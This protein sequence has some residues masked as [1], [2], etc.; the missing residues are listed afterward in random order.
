MSRFRDSIY[1]LLRKNTTNN[2]IKMR[3]FK[4]FCFKRHPNGKVN[5]SLAEVKA[6]GGSRCSLLGSG[7]R[8]GPAGWAERSPEERWRGGEK[9]HRYT[10][11]QETPSANCWPQR[12]ILIVGWASERQGPKYGL[13]EAPG[14]HESEPAGQKED[15]FVL[16]TVKLSYWSP[17]LRITTFLKLK[18]AKL[19]ACLWLTPYQIK[20]SLQLNIK[21]S[22]KC[23]NICNILMSAGAPSEGNPVGKTTVSWWMIYCRSFMRHWTLTI[24]PWHHLSIINTDANR[25]HAKRNRI[26]Y[27]QHLKTWEDL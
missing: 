10:G 2:L 4:D 6:D 15:Q 27:L 19:T 5:L 16:Q 7:W 25:F 11:G 9:F 8:T 13:S 3:D 18:I 12:L 26:V 21:N 1:M 20:K 23:Q 17:V 24:K 14:Q 22:W